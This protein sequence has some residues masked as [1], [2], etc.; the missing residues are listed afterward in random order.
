[1]I[2]L[3]IAIGAAVGA[4]L[5]YLTDR[6]VQQLVRRMFVTSSRSS[7]PWG[8][9]VV[10]ILGSCALGILISLA[11]DSSAFALL[12]IGLCGS[13]TTYSAFSYETMRLYSVR[14]NQAVANIIITLS[15]GF[16]AASCG[17][18][19]GQLL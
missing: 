8:T 7:F 6:A 16:L 3:L 5:R 13:F 1:M 11:T 17:I 4:P 19:L 10:N 14:P 2:A 12:G 9:T 15:L 18:E